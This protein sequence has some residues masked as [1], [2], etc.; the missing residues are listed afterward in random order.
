MI[1]ALPLN[2]PGEFGG[3][4]NVPHVAEYFGPWC[5]DAATFRSM[6]ENVNRLDLAAHVAENVGT[7]K[8]ASNARDYPVL[9]G[10][11][12]VI[13]LRGPLMKFRSSLAP[14]TSTVDARRMLREAAADPDVS[15]I[16]LRIDSPGGTVSG[17]R[18]LAED[19]ASANK[20]KP[21][22]AYIEDLGASAAYWIAS[23]ARAVYAN[24]T[25]IVGSIGTYAVV[26]D[27]SAQAAAMGIRVH[28]IKAG[29]MKGAGEPGTQISE[30]QLSAWQT[31]VDALNDHF[32]RA[33]ARG[34][35]IAVGDVRNLATGRVWVGAEAEAQRLIDGVRSFDQVLREL[36]SETKAATAPRAVA[37]T[38]TE[39]MTDNPT[40]AAPGDTPPR[41][42]A[43]LQ[44]LREAMPGATAEQLLSC[45]ERS[46]T[47]DEARSEHT[48]RLAATVEKQRGEIEAA[49]AKSVPTTP[50]LAD[51]D[52][53]DAAADTDGNPFVAEVDRQIAAGKSRTAAVLSAAKKYPEAHRAFVHSHN[54][55]YKRP[56]D[57]FARRH[58]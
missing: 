19:V 12:A 7:P 45:V 52:A 17:T 28:V 35:K 46:L 42:A 20:R 47:L 40:S 9:S 23:Q 56:V 53:P 8:A 22:V 30:A 57:A 33:V 29:E 26:Y 3:A 32:L 50:P 43:T 11:I 14:G 1:E 5:V 54:E 36:R 38:E 15:G 10:G 48:Q 55:Q 27:Q 4:L 44:Q 24:A 18:D 31:T 34:R 39:T 41:V 21:V 2:E 58:G 51:G 16:M 49:K 25:A 37:E 13:M 6:V